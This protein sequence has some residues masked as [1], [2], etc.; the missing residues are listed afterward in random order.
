M[1]N[2][3]AMKPL[4]Q[5]QLD[6]YI[7]ENENIEKQNNRF[8]CKTCHG[9]GVDTY[10]RYIVK[11]GTSYACTQ[12]SGTGDIFVLFNDYEGGHLSELKICET[13]VERFG[14]EKEL[15]KNHFS[16][17]DAKT[18]YNDEFKD[19]KFI[20]LSL[21]PQ[22]LSILAGSPKIGKS[23]FVLWLCIQISNGEK[24][25]EY[26]T[27]RGTTLYL[28]LEDNLRRLQNR[29]V[30]LTDYP[31]EN[32][33]IST[34]ANTLN[35][36][37]DNQIASFMEEHNDTNLIVIDT[38]QR[39]RE[40]Q[41]SNNLYGSDYSDI[42]YVK[43]IADKY[44]IAILLVHHMRK[45][46]DSDPFN[47]LTGSTGILGAVDC[48]MALVKDSRFESK[49]TLHI[50]SRDEA[51]RQLVVCFDNCKWN[52][53]SNDALEYEKMTS[54]GNS[55][56]VNAIIQF[57][58]KTKNWLGTATELLELLKEYSNDLPLQANKLTREINQY[59]QPLLERNIVVENKT[60]TGKRLINLSLVSAPSLETAKTKENIAPP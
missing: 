10:S 46:P 50:T 9:K 16:L 13:L 23:W 7:S 43:S 45:M 32:M 12:C 56:V 34:M 35:G 30:K 44:D 1:Y 17:T 54:F 36:G 26:E 55:D 53:I 25:W 33:Y 60:V 11:V 51:E 39:I 14:L 21:L 37:L 2:L 31:P 40:P 5:K 8:V 27:L 20:V 38:L 47:M 22:G 29:L 57:I 48:A 59:K 18:L 41:T 24:V 19:F 52:L 6:R 15:S 3:E 58:D 28:S 42:A 4:V 49:A